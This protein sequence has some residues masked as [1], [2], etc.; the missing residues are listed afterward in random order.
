MS[1]PTLRCTVC[2]QTEYHADGCTVARFEEMA[3]H[4]D[5]A[6]RAFAAVFAGVWQRAVVPADR[7]EVAG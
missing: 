3:E 2:C 1:R 6:D 7:D 4:G 5:T